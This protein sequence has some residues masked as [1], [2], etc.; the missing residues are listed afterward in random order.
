[1]GP[2][3][4]SILAFVGAHVI[5][6]I[7]AIR[8]GL[9]SLIGKPAYLLAYSLLSIALITWVIVE[10]RYAPRIVLW[11]PQDWQTLVPLLAVPIAAWLLIAGMVEPNPLSVSLRST[12]A[13]E[14]GGMARITRHP[15]LWA[16]L[17]WAASHVVANG[18]LVSL[19]MFGGLALLALGGFSLVD[20][21][22]RRRLGESHWRELARG[23]SIVPFAAILAGRTRLEW[24][25]SLT[26]T[27]VVAL[28]A[29]IWFVHQGH[30]WLVGVDPLARF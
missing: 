6:P 19:I 10:A 28:A 4:V 23:T 20:F 7:P 18:D 2:F 30:L 24:T 16:F 1:M 29:S 15:V 13:R 5:L 8:N 17:L 22:V 14:V 9:I 3:L 27:A 26:I 25:W 21:R 12:N 11:Q